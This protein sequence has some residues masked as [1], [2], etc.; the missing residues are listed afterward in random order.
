[1]TAAKLSISSD[2]L[3]RRLLQIEFVDSL[4]SIARAQIKDAWKSSAEVLSR[5]SDFGMCCEL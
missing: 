2:E 5:L 1:M 4:T 3:R